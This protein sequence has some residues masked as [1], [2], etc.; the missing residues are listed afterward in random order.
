M[1]IGKR[2]Y[3]AE[4]NLHDLMDLK[5]DVHQAKE[6]SPFPGSERDW[7]I[8][9]DEKTPIGAILEEITNANAPILEKVFLLDLYK[10]DKIGKDRKNATFRLVYRDPKKTVAFEEV[11]KQ[12]T[13]ITE[14]IA[15]KFASVV[16]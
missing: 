11:E 8:T 13:K 16:G 5:R 9:L 10:S 15:K 3:Y 2:V 4:I 12:H 14:D 1:G 7:T 6:F